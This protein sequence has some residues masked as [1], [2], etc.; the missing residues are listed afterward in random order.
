MGV[1]I[2]LG[3]MFAFIVVVS[4]LDSIARRHERSER[5]H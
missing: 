4:V 2:I 3:T 1:Y 5:K